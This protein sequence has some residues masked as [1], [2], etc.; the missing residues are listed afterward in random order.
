MGIIGGFISGWLGIGGGIL[1]TPLLLYIPPAMG[2][3]SIGVKSITGITITQGLFGGLF[4]AFAHKR[5][6]S[7]NIRL[8]L[9][10]GIP[11]FF[12][13]LLGASI[14][15]Y[16]SDNL[17][18]GIFACLALLALFFMIL[19]IKNGKEDLTSGDINFNIYTALIISSIIGSLCGM[20]GQGGS[21]ILIPFMIYVLK[22]PTRIA[23]GSNLAIIIF[24][25]IAGF[26]GKLI[27]GQIPLY[28]AIS[29][30]IGLIPGTQLGGFVSR[31][32]QPKL[33]R[34]SL[35]ILIGI[36]SLKILKD[37]LNI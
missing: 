8:V 2:V 27:T 1:M 19:T 31:K 14:S 29:L 30:I 18:L 33:L 36:V 32:T 5:F 4:G 6:N 37:I 23:L 20:I 35:A 13:S 12:S 11:L 17:I 21:F 15:S 34:I 25:S 16:L 3:G 28:L 26:L 24:S 7:V 22:I 9:W 10:I